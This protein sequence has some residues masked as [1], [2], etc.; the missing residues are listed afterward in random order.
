[1]SEFAQGSLS[2]NAR[3]SNHG[4]RSFPTEIK[5]NVRD[6]DNVVRDIG[7]HVRIALLLAVTAAATGCSPYDPELGDQP[8][9]C[10]D[11]EPRCP[12]GYVCVERIGSDQVCQSEAAVSDAGG[13]G[14]LQCS[15]DTLE[16]NDTIETAT[17]IPIPDAGEMQM[18][19]A[20]V[21]P[22]TDRDIYRLNVDVTGKNVRVEVNY[23]SSAGQL[24]VDLLN[25]TGISI[26]TGTASATNPDR[27]RADFTNLAQGTYYGRVQGM[28]MVNNYAATFIVTANVLPP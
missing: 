2:E 17:I 25:S 12:D 20:V 22:A 3:D 15:G 24:V 16:P 8:F 26:R 21:C 10:G 5:V 19:T 1:L 11:R 14:N 6:P 13:D 28:G 18:R 27:V 9:L 7:G 23:E 4:V